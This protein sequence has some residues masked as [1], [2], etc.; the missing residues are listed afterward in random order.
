MREAFSISP[1][2]REQLDIKTTSSLSP[3]VRFSSDQSPPPPS[4]L[5]A[6]KTSIRRDC[7]L[8]VSSP[9]TQKFKLSICSNLDPKGDNGEGGNWTRLDRTDPHETWEAL[10]ADFAWSGVVNNWKLYDRDRVR[11]SFMDSVGLIFGLGPEAP[12]NAA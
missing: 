1:R 3:F 11:I 6:I 5:L 7:S 8:D 9:K 12:Y 4:P 10:Y 2:W